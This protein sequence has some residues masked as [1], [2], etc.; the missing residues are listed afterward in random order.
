[1]EKIFHAFLHVFLVN[2]GVKL[3]KIFAEVLRV[4]YPR[5]VLNIFT[6]AKELK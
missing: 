6:E 4:M 5:G 3:K 2:L 1:M